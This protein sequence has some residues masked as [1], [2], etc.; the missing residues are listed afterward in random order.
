MPKERLVD[1]C[2]Y[3][4]T[5]NRVSANLVDQVF[6]DSLRLDS[7]A[8]LNELL[9]VK[10]GL[11]PS[12]NETTGWR[13][14][15]RALLVVQCV[16]DFRGEKNLAE[17]ISQQR[18]TGM[19]IATEL[20]VQNQIKT[21]LQQGPAFQAPL[22]DRYYLTTQPNTPSE[23]YLFQPL[24][25]SGSGPRLLVPNVEPLA[26]CSGF[27]VEDPTLVDF[28]QSPTIRGVYTI[29]ATGGCVPVAFVYGGST[30]APIEAIHMHHLYGDQQTVAKYWTALKGTRVGNPSAVVV[31]IYDAG[32]GDRDRMM[33][34]ILLLGF[35]A[36]IV[37]FYHDGLGRLAID[38]WGR[39]G[40]ML[41]DL[42]AN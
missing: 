39:F 33:K 16:F 29:G 37:T 6:Q 2:Q 15:V 3:M 8:N 7:K 14:A 35:P 32:G 5:I 18:K 1:A 20:D 40:S 31:Y 10:V 11:F 25:H 36:N 17:F 28:S 23:A 4:K 24:P 41:G 19:D 22:A 26:V 12:K 42:K 34:Q 27:R 13:S 30:G 21:R 9:K 38:K